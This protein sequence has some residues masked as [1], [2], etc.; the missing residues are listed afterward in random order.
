EQVIVLQGKVSPIQRDAIA[1]TPFDGKLSLTAVS[2]SGVQRFVNVEALA[3]SDA[4]L[5][6]NAQVKNSNGAF[7]STG[8]FEAQTA[9]I[10]GVDV[11]YPIT[12][13]YQVTG[14]LNESSA[15]IQRANLKLGPTPVSI[16]GS[17]DA[18]PKPMQVDMTVQASNA[19]IA[20]AAR[21][22]AA[23]GVAFNARNDVSGTLNMNIHGKGPVTKAALNGQIAARNVRMSGGELRE[24]VQVDAID[25]SLSPDAIRSNQFTA[26]TGRT[27]ATVQ[28]TLSGYVSDSPTLQAQL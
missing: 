27:S 28:F 19:S 15:A 6:G 3:N 22:A 16:Q 17:I 20:E 23:F 9:R 1:R 12:L 21:L 5:T 10:H 14:D 7:A 8:R 13:D 26:R 11:G 24:P 25:L 18:K 4:V 2:L